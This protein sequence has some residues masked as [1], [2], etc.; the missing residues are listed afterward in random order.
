MDSIA[1]A[2]KKMVLI[3]RNNRK[4]KNKQFYNKGKNMSEQKQ[5]EQKTTVSTEPV[6]VSREKLLEAGTYFGHR[7]SR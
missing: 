7:V 3:V 2:N 4:L 6:I 1:C 5:V